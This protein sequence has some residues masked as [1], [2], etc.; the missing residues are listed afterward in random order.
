MKKKSNRRDSSAQKNHFRLRQNAHRHEHENRQLR[1]G[2]NWRNKQDMFD[3]LWSDLIF[4]LSFLY[5]LK[6]VNCG[7][8]WADVVEYR[9]AELVVLSAT[10][11]ISLESL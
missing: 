10:K 2:A 6:R 3:D 9:F 5:A 4:S 7:F 11:Q 8:E 1:V